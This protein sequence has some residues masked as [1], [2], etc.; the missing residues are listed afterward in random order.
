MQNFNIQD[1]PAS[2]Q[3]T[4]GGDVIEEENEGAS[5]QFPSGQKELRDDAVKYPNALGLIFA[6]T[7]FMLMTNS[8]INTVFKE[9]VRM[10]KGQ[11]IIAF[12]DFYK[13]LGKSRICDVQRLSEE[14]KEEL[15]AFLKMEDSTHL[16][17]LKLQNIMEELAQNQ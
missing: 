3:Q 10:Y 15:K 1:A 14:S 17:A 4:Y 16:D 2:P 7:Q 8:S 6:I 9:G 11:S 5:S 12:N 13:T